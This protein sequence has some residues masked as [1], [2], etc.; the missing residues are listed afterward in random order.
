MIFFGASDIFC[1]FYEGRSTF[2]VREAFNLKK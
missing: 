2:E 1:E